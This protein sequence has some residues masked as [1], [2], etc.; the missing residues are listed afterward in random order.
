SLFP[1]PA[2]R[3]RSRADPII[4]ELLR[5]QDLHADGFRLP[6]AAG[7]QLVEEE[8]P[9]LR[10]RRPPQEGRV[11]PVDDPPQRF[12][13]PQKPGDHLVPTGTPLQPR[14]PH[15]LPPPAP[16]PTPTP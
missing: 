10:V 15:P 14:Q 12:L 2:A 7:E 16:R 11:I 3:R 9:P 4:E 1:T 6:G 8:L 5:R 13:A